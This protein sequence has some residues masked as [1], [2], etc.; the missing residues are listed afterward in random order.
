MS[1]SVQHYVDERAVL[2][3]KLVLTRRKG[4]EVI[5][6]GDR[7]DIGLD[8]FVRVSKPVAGQFLPSFGVQI[9]ATSDPLGYE[10]AASRHANK[11][12][13]PSVKGSFLFPIVVFLFSME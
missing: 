13:P 3:A 10:A 6:T 11:R 12:K 1:D 8:L 4:V 5:T 2:L 7:F 9:I